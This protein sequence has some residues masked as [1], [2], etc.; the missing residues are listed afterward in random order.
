MSI[1]APLLGRRRGGPVG[2]GW[3]DL[4]KSDLPGPVRSEKYDINPHAPAPP[5]RRPEQPAKAQD[6]SYRTPAQSNP[7]RGFILESGKEFNLDGRKFRRQHSVGRYILDFFCPSECLGI[8]LDGEVH[9]TAN[10]AE[11]D[12]ERKLFLL[13]SGIKVIRFENK[14]IFEERDRVIYRI[15]ENYGW[16][17]RLLAERTTPS[18]EAVATPPST[19]E[20]S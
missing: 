7:C 3:F 16:K 2:P 5:S 13:H 6:L 11:Y 15:R 18:A 17:Q 20:G 8:E 4:K 14:L 19:K 10:A 9:F 12:R 1:K